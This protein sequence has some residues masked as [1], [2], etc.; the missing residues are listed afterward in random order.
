MHMENVDFVELRFVEDINSNRFGLL[1]KFP[2][3]FFTGGAFLF[4]RRL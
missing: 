2:M 3:L 4:A 1:Q